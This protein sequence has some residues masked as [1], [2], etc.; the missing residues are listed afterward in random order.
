MFSKTGDGSL[1]YS[2]TVPCVKSPVLRGLTL[3][4]V[5]SGVIEFLVL[6]RKYKKWQR[7][8]LKRRKIQR[9]LM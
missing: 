4:L 7:A 2:N 6:M 8:C 5:H 3:L 1:S 9:I